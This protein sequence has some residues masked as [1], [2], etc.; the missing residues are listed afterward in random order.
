MTKFIETALIVKRRRDR[1]VAAAVKSEMAACLDS[2]IERAKCLSWTCVKPR[3]GASS[4]NKMQRDVLR[5]GTAGSVCAMYGTQ[6]R[7]Q[8]MENESGNRKIAGRGTTIR[9]CEGVVQE[10]KAAGMLK[11]AR[12]PMRGPKW[13]VSV[14]HKSSQHG[15][16]NGRH[17]TPRRYR[18]RAPMTI[19]FVHRRLRKTTDKEESGFEIAAL[20][21]R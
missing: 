16:P 2:S 6:Y 12:Q 3:A 8:R 1:R 7:R 17:P 13:A 10:G 5:A 19:A 14:Q 21:S 11:R 15:G 20:D 9:W 18:S 4:L